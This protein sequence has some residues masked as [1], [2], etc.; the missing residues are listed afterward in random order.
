MQ[1]IDSIVLIDINK[2]IYY[3][4]DA[5][6]KILGIMNYPKWICKTLGIIPKSVRDFLR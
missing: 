3:K 6:I 4:S 1:Q 2:K 5:V